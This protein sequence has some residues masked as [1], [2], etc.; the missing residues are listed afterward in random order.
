MQ[1]LNNMVLEALA[2][3]LTYKGALQGEAAHL[4]ASVEIAE[5]LAVSKKTLKG[6]EITYDSTT[7]E[8]VYQYDKP[9]WDPNE[10]GHYDQP[11]TGKAETDQYWTAKGIF[12]DGVYTFTKDLRR[13]YVFL[14]ILI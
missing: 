3:K 4:K 2:K 14:S 11:I 5:G 10:T 7:G 1:N 6:A 13:F 12:K 8:G 9:Q